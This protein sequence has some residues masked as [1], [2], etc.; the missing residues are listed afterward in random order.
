MLKVNNKDTRIGWIFPVTIHFIHVVRISLTP[1]RLESTKMSHILKQ[2]R[3]R[4][5]PGT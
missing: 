2:T 5:G 3:R 1:E 4:F